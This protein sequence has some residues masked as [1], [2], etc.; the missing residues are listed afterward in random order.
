M[1]TASRSFAPVRERE[2][3]A[4][5]DWLSIGAPSGGGLAD[6]WAP[7]A[8]FG[9]QNGREGGGANIPSGGCPFTHELLGRSRG[10]GGVGGSWDRASGGGGAVMRGG[11]CMVLAGAGPGALASAIQR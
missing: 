8:G 5:T 6:P 4:A 2:I 10:I 11:G 3:T 9:V 1:T 7:G